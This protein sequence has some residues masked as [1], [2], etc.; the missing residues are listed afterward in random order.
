MVTKVGLQADFMTALKD[1][2][3]LDYDAVE[4]YEAA[5]NRVE[6]EEYKKTLESFKKDHLR[7][8]EELSEFLK[9]NNETPPTGPSP[10]SLLTQGKVVLANLVSE[11]MI[12]R[13][14]RSN[15]IDTNTAY[16]RIN[17]YDDIPQELKGTLSRDLQ[18]EKRHLAWLE[19][20]LESE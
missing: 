20:V 3:S 4:A 6:D 7:H 10:K 14:M 19:K 17:N 1:L 18:D 11:K 8:I 5:I 9:N 16:G 13:A 15:E 12:L 2:V